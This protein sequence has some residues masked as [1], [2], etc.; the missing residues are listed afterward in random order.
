LVMMHGY[1][2]VELSLVGSHEDRVESDRTP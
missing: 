1:D 2:G